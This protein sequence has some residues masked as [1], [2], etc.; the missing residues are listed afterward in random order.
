M[1]TVSLVK[2]GRVSLTKEDGT[3]YSEVRFGAN[4]GAIQ[5][6]GGTRQVQKK[7]GFF[8]RLIGAATAVIE[9]VTD[10]PRYES[11]D[12]DLS[13]IVLDEN[14][15]KVDTIYFGH[16]TGFGG[17]IHHSGDDLTGD[18]GGDDGQDNETITVKLNN[19][20]PNAIHV[21]FVL[22]SF[23]HH[24]FDEIPHMGC[25]IYAGRE[26]LASFNIAND[27]GFQGKEAMVI[28]RFYKR[29]NVWKFKAEGLIN[30]D[31]SIGALERTVKG[32]I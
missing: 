18:Q 4:W 21:F 29:N 26:T 28:G 3:T 17:A 11:V 9:E 23:R 12:L 16:K 24:K 14:G 25:R 5:R 30:N 13:A 10:A 32:L 19:L 8:S 6:G 20:P 27:S 1:A 15:N 2:G 31:G 22:N 7:A